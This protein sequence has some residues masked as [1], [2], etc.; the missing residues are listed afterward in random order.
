MRVRATCA[1][2]IAGLVLAGCASVPESR[3]EPADGKVA[4]TDQQA[5]GVFDRYDEIN[6]AANA[7]LDADGIAAVE[8]EPLLET[9]VTGFLLAEAGEGE[10]TDPYYHTDVAGYSPRF[11]EYPMWFVATARINAD[12]DRITVQS[13]T[14]DSANGEWLI[15]QAVNLG[16]ADL[17]PITVVDG[18]TPA[19]TDDQ[20]SDVAAALEQVYA[21]LAGGDDPDSVDVTAEGL[22]SYRTWADESTI[23]LDE[24]TAPEISCETDGRAEV[25]VLPTENGAL[26]LAT[27]RCT[28]RQ[29]VDEDVPGDMTLGG[30]LSVLA[31]EPGRTVEFVSS[32]PLVV[33]VPDTGAAEALSGGWRWLDV[34]ML[35]E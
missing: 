19:A 5:A 28:L 13:L 31:P 21:Y 29:S 11:D 10:Q 1:A 12:P 15:E 9:S 6:N 8:A 27:A 23:Q 30:E 32:H 26:G 33:V 18:A 22:A 14:R 20:V 3:P 7:E 34:T 35:P 4:V 17:P 16:A 2:A 25:R 24:V